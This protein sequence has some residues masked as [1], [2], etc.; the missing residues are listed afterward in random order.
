MHVNYWKDCFLGISILRE[1]NASLAT[2]VMWPTESSSIMSLS[3]GGGGGGVEV[4]WQF[5]GNHRE[6]TLW[7]FAN[8][9]WERSCEGSLRNL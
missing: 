5:W 3:R 7:K 2:S 9:L 1:L 6:S 8:N 4:E